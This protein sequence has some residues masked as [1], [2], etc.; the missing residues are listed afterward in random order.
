MIGS[1]RIAFAM[2]RIMVRDID[3]IIVAGLKGILYL[4][5]GCCLEIEVPV[6]VYE[7]QPSGSLFDLIHMPNDTPDCSSPLVLALVPIIH[8]DIK[9]SNILLDESYGAKVSDFGISRFASMDSSL[10]TTL[11]QGTFGILLLEPAN[12][13]ERC[14]R[15]W[16]GVVLVELMT[17]DK[18]VSFDKSK[19]E[20]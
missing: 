7:F 13:K 12:R 3:V 9:T 2:T 8:I 17:G 16:C 18:A 6:L 11:V 20:A 1:R 15:F 5:E 19:I 10:T 4:L 14:L